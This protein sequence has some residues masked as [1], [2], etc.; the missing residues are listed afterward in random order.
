MIN[1]TVCIM[2]YNEEENIAFC[3]DSLV[4]RFQRICVVDSFST[5]N[6]KKIIQGFNQVE[7]FENKFFHWASQRN[8]LAK[9]AKAQS[10]YILFLDADERLPLSLI[11][12]LEIVLSEKIPDCGEFNF[13]H[14][15][16][17]TNR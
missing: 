5:D 11:K 15:F 14:H 17:R 12:E 3:L 4:G 10:D 16:L 2:T 6:T 1:C 8:W 7:L 13:E 9:E